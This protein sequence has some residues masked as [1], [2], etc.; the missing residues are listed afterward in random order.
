LVTAWSL[1]I[2]TAVPPDGSSE[3]VDP[4]VMACALPVQVVVG[5]TG[6]VS[7]GEMV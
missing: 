2:V 3:P 7:A 1:S 5:L 4:V 6:C